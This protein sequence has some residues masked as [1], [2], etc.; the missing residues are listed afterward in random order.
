MLSDYTWGL[1]KDFRIHTEQSLF[2]LKI[3]AF[4]SKTSNRQFP[5]KFLDY[6][7]Y[8]QENTEMYIQLL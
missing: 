7:Y 1:K 8:T 3:K 2:E 6:L 5:Q 4:I